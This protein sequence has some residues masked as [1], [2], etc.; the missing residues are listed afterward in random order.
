MTYKEIFEKLDYDETLKRSKYGG[1]FCP[2]DGRCNECKI[3]YPKI[4]D[5]SWYCPCEVYTKRYVKDKFW[6]L[7]KLTHGR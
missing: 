7:M 6:K 4:I 2:F 3:I 5:E 1:A